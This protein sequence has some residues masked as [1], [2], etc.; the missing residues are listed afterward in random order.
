MSYIL[1]EDGYLL[2]FLI[3]EIKRVPFVNDE[4]FDWK[5]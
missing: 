1:C 5:M 2:K 4:K 3:A